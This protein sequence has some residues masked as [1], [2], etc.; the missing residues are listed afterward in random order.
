[1]RPACGAEAALWMTASAVEDYCCDCIL[2]HF[3]RLDFWVQH[4]TFRQDYYRSGYEMVDWVSDPLEDF[5]V[6]SEPDL[7][8]SNEMKQFELVWSRSVEL[9]GV[10]CQSKRRVGQ[11]PHYFAV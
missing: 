4:Q 11:L 2:D 1:V 10:H 5:G 9:Y 3:H 6:S 7:V 8:G